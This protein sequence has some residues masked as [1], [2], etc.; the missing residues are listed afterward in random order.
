M[1]AYRNFSERW[2]ASY[3]RGLILKGAHIRRFAVLL[4]DGWLIPS[5]SSTFAFIYR[6]PKPSAAISRLNRQK[7]G[8]QGA[9]RDTAG[10][11]KNQSG[12]GYIREWVEK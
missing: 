8:F 6:T 3:S 4:L 9:I 11:G 12:Q 5:A 7:M 10:R 2:A 1:G